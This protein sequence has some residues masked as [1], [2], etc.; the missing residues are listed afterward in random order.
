MPADEDN[1][2]S[3]LVSR[4]RTISGL[5]R[6]VALAA[7]FIL[8]AVAISTLGDYIPADVILVFVGLLAVVVPF[9]GSFWVALGA[10]SLDLVAALVVTSLLRRRLSYRRWRAIHWSAYGAWPAP[11]NDVRNVVSPAAVASL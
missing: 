4:P 6:V 1:Y 9:A 3:P 2:P 10:I 5:W 7:G 8:V 11:S